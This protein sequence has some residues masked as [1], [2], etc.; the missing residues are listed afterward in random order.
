MGRQHSQSRLSARGMVHGIL[1]ED[2][3]SDVE[4]FSQI[5]RTILMPEGL[6]WHH[7]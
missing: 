2:E 5:F 1:H 3:A 6:F 4:T 7:T